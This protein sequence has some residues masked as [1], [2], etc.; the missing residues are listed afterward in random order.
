[1]AVERLAHH[2][3]GALNPPR[4]RA[5]GVLQKHVMGGDVAQVA[6]VIDIGRRDP[7][8]RLGNPP[9]ERGFFY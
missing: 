9:P 1:M 7:V 2:E 5:V 8:H 4:Q 3:C 6:D